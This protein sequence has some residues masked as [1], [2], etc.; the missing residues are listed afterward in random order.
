MNKTVNAF[1][2]LLISTLSFAISAEQSFGNYYTGF[3]DYVVFDE[4]QCPD[5]L[6]GIPGTL[7]AFYYDGDGA[8]VYFIQLEVVE[9]SGKIHQQTQ[10]VILLK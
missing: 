5:D 4:T 10:K 6:D 1:F 8:G 3:P 9:N 2:I 7:Q